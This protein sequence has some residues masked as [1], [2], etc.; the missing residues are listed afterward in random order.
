MGTALGPSA[1]D[2]RVGGLL[3]PGRHRWLRRTPAGAKHLPQRVRRQPVS[4]VT[5]NSQIARPRAMAAVARRGPCR[6]SRGCRRVVRESPA[7]HDISRRLGRDHGMPTDS[8]AAS[9]LTKPP[10]SFL[11]HGVSCSCLIANLPGQTVGERRVQGGNQSVGEIRQLV[12][13]RCN[14]KELLSC[15]DFPQLPCRGSNV[16]RLLPVIESIFFWR[17]GTHSLLSCPF[18]MSEPSRGIL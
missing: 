9:R 14:H 15:F 18:S 7:L 13:K 10:D 2:Q 8:R 12:V 16:P 11:L 4:L 1:T 3:E 5:A 6:V 17:R